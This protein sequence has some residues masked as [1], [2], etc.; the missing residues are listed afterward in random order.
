MQE[1]D[2]TSFVTD[3]DSRSDIRKNRSSIIRIRSS[4]EQHANK[5]NSSERVLDSYMRSEGFVSLTNNLANGL[6]N[7]KQPNGND[8]RS[9]Q[10]REL[11]NEVEQLK[12]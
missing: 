6:H 8:M 9:Q 1:E 2:L 5:Q 4:L 12:K 7:K 11:I 10:D 3:Q